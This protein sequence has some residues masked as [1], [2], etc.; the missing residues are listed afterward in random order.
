MLLRKRVWDILR[1]DYPVVSKEASLHQAVQALY[2][3]QRKNP[4][5]NFVLVLD[6]RKQFVGLV[7]MWNILQ[8]IGPC[9]MKEGGSLGDV[10]WDAAFEA[11]CLSCSQQGLDQVLQ[12]DVPLVRPND[13]L[14]RVMEVF[15]DYRRGRAVVEEGGQVLG[16]VLLHDLFQVIGQSSGERLR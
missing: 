6:D 2:S 8:S 1:T 9:L 13:T 12:R 14:A 16:M 3:R 4:E 11:S 5:L 10:D 7:S 15:L